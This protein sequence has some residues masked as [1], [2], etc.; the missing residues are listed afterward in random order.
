MFMSDGGRVKA[1]R[2]LLESL[3]V[4]LKLKMDVFLP[5][6]NVNESKNIVEI[7]YSV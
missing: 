4:F 7:L 6:Q 3:G 5:E 2:L 1:W